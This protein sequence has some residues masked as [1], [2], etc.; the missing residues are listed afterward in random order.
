MVNGHYIVE[1]LDEDARSLLYEDRR[2][3]DLRDREIE[4]EDGHHV[5]PIQ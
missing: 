1:T 4:Q 2:V 5:I 3:L